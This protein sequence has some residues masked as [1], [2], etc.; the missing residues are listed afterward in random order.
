MIHTAVPLTFTP[1]LKQ[2]R[3]CPLPCSQGCYLHLCPRSTAH[4]QHR[5]HQGLDTLLQMW[6]SAMSHACRQHDLTCTTM[7]VC[8]HLACPKVIAVT[9]A[10][11][12]RSANAQ[13][14]KVSIACS[15]VAGFSCFGGRYSTDSLYII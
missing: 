1:I 4:C 14:N 8:A 10:T 11:G 5:K 13:I 2:L 7:P 12:H 3:K 9:W 15:T 6:D